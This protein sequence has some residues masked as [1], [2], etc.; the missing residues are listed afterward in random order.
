[1]EILET[2]NHSGLRSKFKELCGSPTTPNLIEFWKC[3]PKKQFLKLHDLALRFIC[4]F[5]STYICEQTFSS[6]NAIK[7]KL[8]STIT[9]THLA[10]M[11]IL[12]TTRIAPS[13]DKLVSEK[14]VQK[15][16]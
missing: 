6:M 11:L 5:G 3:V 10:D 2:Q 4:R 1:M 8:C 15:S 12:S 14:Q 7:S 16:Y 9:N 13:I